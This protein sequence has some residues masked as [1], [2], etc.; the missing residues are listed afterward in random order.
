MGHRTFYYSLSGGAISTVPQ[1]TE[2]SRHLANGTS[3]ASPNACGGIALLLSALKTSGK[4]APLSLMRRA[5]ENSCLPVDS[6]D[7]PSGLTYGKGLLQV[8]TV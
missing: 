4:K 3:M 2:E 7:V 5:L 6:A 1:W 8:C